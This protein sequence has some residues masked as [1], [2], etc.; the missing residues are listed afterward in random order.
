MGTV[1]PRTQLHTCDLDPDDF[2]IKAGKVVVKGGFAGPYQLTQG[3]IGG[4][5]N[6]SGK[7]ELV[8]AGGTEAEPAC[9]WVVYPDGAHVKI[10]WP[11]PFEEAYCEAVKECFL[12]DL[13]QGG[14]ELDKYLIT[15]MDGPT[16]AILSV[17]YGEGQVVD[18]SGDGG[19]DLIDLMG[20]LNLSPN[21]PDG[22]LWTIESGVLVLNVPYG[23]GV[24]LVEMPGGEEQTFTAPSIP[25]SPP[26]SLTGPL[27][28]ALAG[29]LDVVIDQ[30]N[31]LLVSY[32]GLLGSTVGA[33]S[34]D[35]HS[36]VETEYSSY[37]TATVR[38]T[39]VLGIPY[40]SYKEPV[41]GWHHQS[42][43]G[44]FNCSGNLSLAAF[45]TNG[46][47][48]DATS[49]YDA[50]NTTGIANPATNW[51]IGVRGL[52]I[53]ITLRKLGIIGGSP[54]VTGSAKFSSDPATDRN[55]EVHMIDYTGNDPALL[56]EEGVIMMPNN[57][58]VEDSSG[59]EFVLEREDT[60]GSYEL[61][62]VIKSLIF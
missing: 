4:Y 62:Y 60:S 47:S 21:L 26:S 6:Q 49:Y 14:G 2:A 33:S 40:I 41:N 45:L 55:V 48:L 11:L 43:W 22:W 9:V 5:T 20:H 50:Y 32:T 12:D 29:P 46:A 31:S 18:F 61:Y 57:Q 53:K 59:I 37:S 7:P 34:N 38:W 17:H 16:W 24:T 28:T 13:N 15:E 51:P 36:D 1:V 54:S 19:S 3:T 39:H 35:N 30:Y 58:V 52:R 10:K 23:T 42:L 56:V 44:E 25:G 8:W 27:T